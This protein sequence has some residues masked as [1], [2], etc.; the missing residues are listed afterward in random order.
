M[1]ELRHLFLVHG[2]LLWSPFV[3]C[4]SCV[5][6]SSV[7]SESIHRKH[8]LNVLT[9]IPSNLLDPCRILVCGA[10]KRKTTFKFFFSQTGWP[11][12]NKPS[13]LKCES[14]WNLSKGNKQVSNALLAVYH[15]WQ[16][17]RLWWP[18]ATFYISTNRHIYSV[19]SSDL[20]RPN[21]TFFLNARKLF[22]TENITGN[23]TLDRRQIIWIAFEVFMPKPDA[24]SNPV[25]ILLGKNMS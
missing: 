15:S 5:N 14:K 1:K 12:F 24:Q 11:I 17:Y 6:I 22:M 21:T 8:P 10:A 13:I 4:A 23:L 16:I 25:S 3:L 9:R 20:G 2:E 18:F 7:T 19:Y